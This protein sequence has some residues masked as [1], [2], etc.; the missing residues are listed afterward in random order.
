MSFSFFKEDIKWDL[1]PVAQLLAQ[2]AE[3]LGLYH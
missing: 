2:Y 3:S 1:G